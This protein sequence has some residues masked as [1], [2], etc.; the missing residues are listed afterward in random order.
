MNS[1]K[2]FD[3]FC[4]FFLFFSYDFQFSFREKQKKKEHDL[5]HQQKATELLSLFSTVTKMLYVNFYQPQFVSYS[6]Y[7]GTSYLTKLFIIYFQN[8]L[9]STY[10]QQFIS[11]QNYLKIM[12][13][14]ILTR[15]L[16]KKRKN[17]FFLLVFCLFVSFLVFEHKVKSKEEV[18]NVRG[19]EVFFP[20][21]RCEFWKHFRFFFQ[22]SAK[23]KFCSRLENKHEKNTRNTKLK[24]Y[25]VAKQTEREI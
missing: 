7:F 1:I 21:Y 19:K 18:G 24:R 25:S 8:F 17:C 20:L 5:A 3:Y 6:L 9:L 4:L 15:K 11:N 23:A 2:C 13:N 14:K 16:A 12:Y 22:F 10:L